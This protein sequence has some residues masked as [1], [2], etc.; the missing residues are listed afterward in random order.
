MVS[1]GLQA[2]NQRFIYEYQFKNDSSDLEKPL[3][4]ELMYL[5]IAAKG[6]K[7]YSRD[8][9]VSDSIFKAEAEKQSGNMDVN[10]NMTGRKSGRIRHVIEKSYPEFEISQFERLGIDQYKV[11]DSRTQQWQ[12]IPEKEKVGEFETQKAVTNFAGRSWTA[13]FVPE[14]PFQDGPYKFRGLPG[15]IVKVEDASKTHI[16]EL[17]SSQKLTEADEWKSAGEWVEVFRFRP[18]IP[19]DENQFKKAYIEYR[20]DPYRSYK[21]IMA[22][23]NVIEHRDSSGALI[24]S[25]EWMRDAEKS[26][27][28]RNE[29]L[30]NLLELDLLKS[31]KTG[32]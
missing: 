29:R 2:Q 10:I 7:Y 4:K 8:F 20:N 18:L 13:W 16:F 3:E 21:Q 25:Q 1:V 30:N 15:L 23:G 22:Q 14:I 11:S 24:D 9:F 31:H 32:T 5:D 12:I 26:Q 28:E 17:K 19:L 6:S 27:K